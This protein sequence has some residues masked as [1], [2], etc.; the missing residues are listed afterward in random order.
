MGLL[1]CHHPGSAA[2][3]PSNGTGVSYSPWWNELLLRIGHAPEQPGEMKNETSSDD[4]LV[5][6]RLFL[7]GCSRSGTTVVQRTLTESYR[8]Y[9]LPETDFFGL[10]VGGGLGAIA[11][12]LGISRPAKV[13]RRAFVRLARLLQTDALREMETHN[14]RLRPSIDR[15]VELL[16]GMALKADE[17]GWL[18]KTPKHF[19]HT[20]LIRRFVPAAQIIYV[21]RRGPDVVASIRDRANRFPEQ[22]S[23]QHN[24]DYAIKLWNRSIRAALKDA[25][26]G[27]ALVVM[28]EDFVDDHEAIVRTI[29]ELLNLQRR[30]GGTDKLPGIID[31]S[32]QWKSNSSAAVRQASS[33]FT[34]VFDVDTR[35]LILKKL[36]TQAY[37]ALASFAISPS[38]IPAVNKKNH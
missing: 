14:W 34:Q 36:N 1:F 13:Y 16:D 29:G 11:C 10:L 21:V 28:Y 30:R 9:S 27:Q 22:F 31:I 6:S 20:D 38:S 15:F 8:L 4:N 3:P 24:P 25:R 19:R 26:R 2:R 37:D 33:K 32:E 5:L 18:E 35:N 7:V 17:T 12:R 23:R